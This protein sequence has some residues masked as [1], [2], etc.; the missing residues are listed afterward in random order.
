MIKLEVNSREFGLILDSI[1]FYKKEV[2]RIS[3]KKDT[4]KWRK[5]NLEEVEKD[6]NKILADFGASA[7]K[8][9]DK[10]LGLK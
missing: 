5:K 3:K 6:L 7:R 1:T 9:A 10:N 2:Y 8:Y 4:E